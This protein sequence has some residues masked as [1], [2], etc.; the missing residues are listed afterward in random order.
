[1][2]HYYDK[3]GLLSPAA[4]G[5]NSYRYYTIKQLAVC[6][7]IR[8][9]QKIDVPLAEI[10]S[11]ID[12]RTP[13]LTQEVLVRQIGDLSRKQMQLAQAQMLLHTMLRSINS[14]LKADEDVISV[15]FLPAERIILG[16]LN[17]YSG[18]R[19]DY[20]ALYSFYQE[21]FD[22]EYPLNEY[23]I[24]YPVWA[25]ISQERLKSGRW[26]YPDRYYFFNPDGQE[27]RPEGIYAVGHT[28]AGYGKGAHL[29]T[30]M[31][32]YIESNGLEICGDAYEEYP[33]NEVGVTDASDY[34]M[35]LLITVREKK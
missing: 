13:E 16:G 20:D 34:L 8:A 9:L 11:L 26:E 22:K 19:T 24:C 31:F 15:Q 10:K 17:D 3:I 28:R 27:L 1:M 2:L 14:G 35:R 21:M 5:D 4:R 32:E 29:Y 12:R 18:G 30:K 25:V 23:D 6:N 7:M 33:L